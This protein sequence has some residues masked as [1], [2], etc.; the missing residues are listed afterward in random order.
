[1]SRNSSS[2]EFRPTSFPISPSRT[3]ISGVTYYWEH[4][5]MLGDRGYKKRWQDK[6]Q[7]Y[8][9]QGIFPTKKGRTKGKHSSSAAGDPKGG[10]DS[11]LII[12][13]IEEVLGA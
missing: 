3:T 6:I 7:W 11:S 9:A 4:L 1:M 13:L 12:R 5:G 2:T 10:I 8:R